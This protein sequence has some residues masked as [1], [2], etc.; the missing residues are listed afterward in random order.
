MDNSEWEERRIDHGERNNEQSDGG[1]S[2]I[3]K[4]K[5]DADAVQINN[6][7]DADEEQIYGCELIGDERVWKRSKE[8]SAEWILREFGVEDKSDDCWKD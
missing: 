8:V 3:R 6:L 1:A 2:G 4:T 7:R 5:D